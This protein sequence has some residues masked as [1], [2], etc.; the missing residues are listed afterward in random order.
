MSLREEV[1]RHFVG[2]NGQRNDHVKHS[3]DDD[4]RHVVGFFLK[5]VRAHEEVPTPAK[6]ESCSSAKKSRMDT[7]D[8]SYY[9]EVI[10]VRAEIDDKV[11]QMKDEMKVQLHDLFGKL[12]LQLKQEKTASDEAT[13]RAQQEKVAYQAQQAAYLAQQQQAA[14]AAQAAAAFEQAEREAA[15]ALAGV[16]GLSRRKSEMY[17]DGAPSSKLSKY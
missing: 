6:I 8:E 15:A 7:D 9:E 14:H 5:T 10:D 16:A 1:V 3:V 11:N 4:G 12:S 17:P 2:I 13:Y